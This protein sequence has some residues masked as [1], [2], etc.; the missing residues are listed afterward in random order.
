M[1]DIDVDSLCPNDVVKE[2]YGSVLREI[3]DEIN[4]PQTALSEPELMG[5]ARNETSGGRPSLEFLVR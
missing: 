1:E 5:I 4:I 3:Q 2:I